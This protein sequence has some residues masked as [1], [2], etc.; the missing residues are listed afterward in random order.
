[1]VI[2]RRKQSSGKWDSSTYSEKVTA[3]IARKA[4]DG[5]M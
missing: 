4:V 5:R 3:E 2:A 1:M